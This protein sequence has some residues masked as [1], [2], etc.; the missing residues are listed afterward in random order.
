MLKTRKPLKIVYISTTIILFILV[1]NIL[2]K[3]IYIRCNL[4]DSTE[5]YRL[6]MLEFIYLLVCLEIGLVNIVM[7]IIDIIKSIKEFITIKFPLI[8][9][10]I[11]IILF[12]FS[13]FEIMFILF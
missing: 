7:T 1:L 6:E 12:I 13:I 3:R 9:L 10:I 11:N 5:Y 4:V 8:M 2:L